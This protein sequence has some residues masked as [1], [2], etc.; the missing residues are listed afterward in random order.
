MYSAP[1]T[2][3]GGSSTKGKGEA[4]AHGHKDTCPR[5]PHYLDVGLGGSPSR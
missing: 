4:R 5:G 1:R 2:F 3:L